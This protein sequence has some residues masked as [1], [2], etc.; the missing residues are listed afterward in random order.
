MQ[1]LSRF[2]VF[3]DG[4][5]PLCRRE[6]NWLRKRDRH[7]KIEFIDI[8]SPEF[9]EKQFGKSFNELMREIHGRTE[10]GRWVTGVEVFRHLYDAAGF[11]RV[12]RVSRW[13]IVRH[14]LNVS[15]RVFAKYRTRI[16]GRCA[17]DTCQVNPSNTTP[18]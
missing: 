18:K 10:E 8:A 9:C 3:F 14:G 4:A 6:I 17:D 11:Q 1:D 15:Y 12:V 5:C 7:R 13:P 16:T 2:Q